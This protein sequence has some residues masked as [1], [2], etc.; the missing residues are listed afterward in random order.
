MST[1]TKPSLYIVDGHSHIFRAYHAVGYLS[2]SR[3]VPSHAVLILSTRE[4]AAWMR[5]GDR[6]G[7]DGMPGWALRIPDALARL[8][9]H[10][11]AA[12]DLGPALAARDRGRVERAP[13]MAV[14]AT[15]GDGPRDWLV[16]GQALARVL[17][18]ACAAGVAASFMNQPLEVPALRE[19]VTALL[20]AADDPSAPG[21]TA[22]PQLVLRFGYAPEGRPTPRRP[23]DDVLR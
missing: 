15:V 16:A 2:T 17:L 5:P 13:T 23:V 7:G 22:M 11:V 6:T 8:A 21:D 4:L 18:T 1:A 20:Q 19:R 12:A 3:G 10:V 14:L 9:P